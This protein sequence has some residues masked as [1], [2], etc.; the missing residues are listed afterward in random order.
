MQVC[1][2]F[3]IPRQNF[4]KALTQNTITVRGEK[5]DAVYNAAQAKEARDS[6]AKT[7]YHRMFGWI[8]NKVNDL[9]METTLQVRA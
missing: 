1:R 8:V 3:E 7:I 6:V 9:L 5:I 4:E 2:L